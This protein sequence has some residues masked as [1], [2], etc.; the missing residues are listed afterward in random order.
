MAIR[1]TPQSFAA[2]ARRHAANG[3]D[4]RKIIVALLLAAKL[5]IPVVRNSAKQLRA[6]DTGK[7]SGG[8]K[9]DPTATGAILYNPVMYTSTI[10]IG[11]RPG[12]M[13][14]IDP[15][16][17]WV[18][19]KLQPG[20]GPGNERRIAR[21]VQLKIYHRGTAARY[22]VRRVLPILKAIAVRCVKNAMA[23]PPRGGTP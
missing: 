3:G 1:Y 17:G 23:R 14:P 21:L 8:W 13:P 9:A 4:T 22:V 12:T 18:H 7:M 11:R 6:F 15:L 16:V 19:R 2:F 5:G 20:G 10:E